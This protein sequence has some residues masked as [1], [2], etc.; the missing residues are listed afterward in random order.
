M[1]DFVRVPVSPDIAPSP[2]PPPP[3]AEPRPLTAQEVSLWLS[4]HIN[5]VK[6]LPA[7]D[8]PYFTIGD[9]GD[10]RYFPSDVLAYITARRKA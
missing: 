9:R 1:S 5:T 2:P 6:R 7:S 3:A 8:L 10:R 4:V